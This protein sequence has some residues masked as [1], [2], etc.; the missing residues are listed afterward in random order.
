[1]NLNKETMKPAVSSSGGLEVEQWSD[2]RTLS[3]SVDQSQLGD[4]MVPLDP[5]CYIRPERVCKLKD[6]IVYSVSCVQ[7][8]ESCVQ[9]AK[10]NN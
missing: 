9:Y 4:Y 1:M 10:V 8:S 3:I 5:L 7:Y 2:N 6:Y